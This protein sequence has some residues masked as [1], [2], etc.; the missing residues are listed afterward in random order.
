MHV[1]L[2]VRRIIFPAISIWKKVV[3]TKGK[4]FGRSVKEQDA[5]TECKESTGVHEAYCGHKIAGICWDWNKI[6]KHLKFIYL[7]TIWVF[8]DIKKI[9]SNCM[10]HLEDNKSSHQFLYAKIKKGVSLGLLLP[11]NFRLQC[12]FARVQS[13]EHES[14]K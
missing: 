8:A 3:V 9:C 6:L 5:K 11:S 13:C 1:I 12:E 4:C 7:K 14:A 2:V 10:Y